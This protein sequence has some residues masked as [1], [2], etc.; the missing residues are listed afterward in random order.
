MRSHTGSREEDSVFDGSSHEIFHA[1]QRQ[2]E[3]LP[4]RTDM[5]LDVNCDRW[6]GIRDKIVF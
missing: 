3:I 2:G 5:R 4:N 6:N 1:S